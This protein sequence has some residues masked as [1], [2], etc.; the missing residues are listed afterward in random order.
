[1]TFLPV[2]GAAISSLGSGG[3]LPVAVS[4]YA[5]LSALAAS[6]DAGHPVP[7]VALVPCRHG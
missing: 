7:D 4:R 5:G 6:L 3:P 1:M 2:A